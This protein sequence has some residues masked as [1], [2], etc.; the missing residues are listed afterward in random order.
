MEFAHCS[1]QSRW[2]VTGRR[3]LTSVSIKLFWR[4]RRRDILGQA[5]PSLNWV[6]GSLVLPTSIRSVSPNWNSHKTEY[7]HI[8]GQYSCYSMSR[9][10]RHKN[11]LD[12]SQ[13]SHTVLIISSSFR[14]LTTFS[15]RQSCYSTSCTIGFRT[16]R[17][18]TTS[19]FGTHISSSSI[20]SCLPSFIVTLLV[21]S[22]CMY[23]GMRDG[24]N[25]SFSNHSIKSGWL[26][27]TSWGNILMYRLYT[28]PLHSIWSVIASSIIL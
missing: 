15:G 5:P 23:V 26:C 27:F 8:C 14:N 3:T 2:I 11:Y 19:S 7:P 6:G 17:N 22:V 13:N 10:T 24:T 25:Y 9:R 4:G 18:L 21:Y 16:G 20:F 1:T 28:T 12:T